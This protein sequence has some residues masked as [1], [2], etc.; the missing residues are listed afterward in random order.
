MNQ[1]VIEILRHGSSD[2]ELL[3]EYASKVQQQ[4]SQI[5][6]VIAQGNVEKIMFEIG[7]LD[8]NISDL[9]GII[10]VMTDNLPREDKSEDKKSE[11]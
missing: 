3:R 2:K 11:K 9:C 8:Y 1:Q 4:M 10:N 5:K 7:K 6:S